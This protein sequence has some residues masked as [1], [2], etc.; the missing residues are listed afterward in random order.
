MRNDSNF[1]AAKNIMR[2]LFMRN[3]LHI[4]FMV[5]LSTE[6]AMAQDM[7]QDS[8][9]KWRVGGNTEM[10][11]SSVVDVPGVS[12]TCDYLPSDKWTLGMEVSVDTEG[13]VSLDQLHVTHT[14]SPALNVRAGRLIVPFGLKNAYDEPDRFFK[15]IDADN[16]LLDIPYTWYENGVE[17]LGTIGRDHFTFDYH[18]FV[19]TGCSGSKKIKDAAYAFRLDYT[20]VPG[21]RVGGCIYHCR[22]IGTICEVDGKFENALVES[23]ADYTYGSYSAEVGMKL[24]GLMHSG[25]FPDIIPFVRYENYRPQEVTL[26]TDAPEE[27][28]ASR[29]WMVGVN[30]RAIQGL[31]VKADYTRRKKDGW[32]NRF[33]VGVAFVW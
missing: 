25:T 13:G 31:T 23:R 10:A 11:C 14:I 28:E 4:L 9:R 30:W 24:T 12:V 33:A 29:A 27:R 16:D 22:D 6:V 18:A 7:L 26:V 2:T 32:S 19:V 5:F 17:L 20:G 15:T 1:A 21:L 3:Y 8:E